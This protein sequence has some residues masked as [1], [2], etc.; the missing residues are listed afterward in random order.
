MDMQTTFLKVKARM[1]SRSETD[2]NSELLREL[3]IDIDETEE[4]FEDYIRINVD[5]IESYHHF[6]DGITKVNSAGNV[7]LLCYDVNEFDKIIK[8]SKSNIINY[9]K[10]CSITVK[11]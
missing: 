5:Y 11:K 9:E 7:Y 10:E 3:G 6:Q 8:L 2:E 4:H 1:V